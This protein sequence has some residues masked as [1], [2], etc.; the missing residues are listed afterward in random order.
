M[1]GLFALLLTVGFA[2]AAHADE[3]LPQM[4]VET[5][6]SQLF[7]LTI[8]FGALYLILGG[9]ILPHISQG[10]SARASHIRDLLADARRLRD[11]AETHKTHM[12]SAMDAAYRHA[13]EV[14]NHAAAEA[15]ELATRRGHE[16]EAAMMD[17]SKESEERI[18]LMRAA[19]VQAV[20]EAVQ[21]LLP[22][23]VQ[24]LADL[25]LSDAQIT[26]AVAEAAGETQPNLRRS[27]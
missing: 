23:V 27:A 4:A 25:K 15:Q 18:T 3:G 7:W 9:A 22:A 2:F 14:L 11:E 20:H 13:H 21:T 6:P 26:A 24:K 1:R 19:S 17:K 5:F 8:T 16:L 12:E 10:M